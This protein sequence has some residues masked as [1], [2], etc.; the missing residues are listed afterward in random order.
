MERWIQEH[1]EFCGKKIEYQTYYFPY[2]TKG[3]NMKITMI[4]FVKERRISFWDISLVTSH[5]ASK[6]WNVN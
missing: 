2:G 6:L 5:N 3:E 1:P 4:R